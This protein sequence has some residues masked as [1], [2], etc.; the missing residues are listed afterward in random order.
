ML[1]DF[2]PFVWHYYW[3]S[4]ENGVVPAGDELEN[5]FKTSQLTDED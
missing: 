3:E 2:A 4:Y 5:I 1:P